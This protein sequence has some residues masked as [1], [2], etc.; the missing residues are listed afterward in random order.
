MASPDRTRGKGSKVKIGRCRLDRRKKSFT[1]RVV[2]HWNTLPR[3]AADALTLESIKITLDKAL[4]N[5][6]S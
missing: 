6:T 4:S 1:M 5:L 2:Q 3:E